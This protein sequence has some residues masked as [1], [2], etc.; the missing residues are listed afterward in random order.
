[1]NNSL[2]M[3]DDLSVPNA[4][5]KQE[6]VN[7][8]DALSYTRPH[9]KH[10]LK[11]VLP[12]LVT[13]LLVWLL[14]RQIEPATMGRMLLRVDGRGVLAGLGFY[15]LTNVWRAYRFGTLM[16][17]KG[18]VAPLSLLPDMIALSFL[19]NV[20]P[21]RGGEL[22][23]PYLLHKRHGTPIGEALTFLVIVRIFDLIAVVTLLLV[24]VGVAHEQ[25]AVTIGW[26]GSGV[27]G[28]I[29]VLLLPVLWLVLLFLPQLV[30]GGYQLLNG[31]LHWLG[32]VDRRV[33]RWL[34]AVGRKAV[35][36]MDKVHSRAIY[37]RVFF[38]S[39]VGWLT[40]FAWFAMFMQA[41][42]VPQPYPLVVVG[43]S[44]ATLS[45]AIPFVTV[46]GFGAHDVG[47]AFGFGLVGMSLEQ[48]IA[49][50]LA[51]N[52]LTLSASV[53]VGG[54]VVVVVRKREL[55]GSR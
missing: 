36:G 5:N 22:S 54:V 1:M 27:I 35:G 47:W 45:K 51:V 8:A 21:G 34:L 9:V 38:W 19:N 24:F 3:P 25:I 18:V 11:H 16:N 13:G 31:A 12:V 50:G 20:L 10:W 55:W 37:A 30:K 40:T 29:Y 46:G 32:L 7:V 33:G 4:P 26:D 15:L 43:A 53:L 28:I 48:A 23:F 42:G 44:F 6:I 49:S 14:L 39:I 41:I 17:I 2:E 52:L